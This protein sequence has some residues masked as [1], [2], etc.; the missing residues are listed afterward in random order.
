MVNKLQEKVH[1]ENNSL[2][3]TNSNINP[4]RIIPKSATQDFPFDAVT[5]RIQNQKKGVATVYFRDEIKTRSYGSGRN[6]QFYTHCD[7]EARITLPLVSAWNNESYNYSMQGTLPK[8]VSFSEAAEVC[9]W[10]RREV[11]DMTGAVADIPFN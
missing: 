7:A 1:W 6:K 9:N 10:I 5:V 8:G 3:K 2:V 11:E 4:K